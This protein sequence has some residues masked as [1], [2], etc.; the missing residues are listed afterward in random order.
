[1]KCHAQVYVNNSMEAIETYCRAFGAKIRF[2]IKNADKTEYDPKKGNI[3]YKWKPNYETGKIIAL[4][5]KQVIYKVKDLKG[6]SIV[7]KGKV[8]FMEA[9]Y[10]EPQKVKTYDFSKFTSGIAEPEKV[11]KQKQKEKEN[12]AFT[13]A[14]N[15]N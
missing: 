15:D 12:F 8:D 11:R 5:S 9:K 6:K 7:N 1:M 4:K 2:E 10:K 3:S 14:S 13:T